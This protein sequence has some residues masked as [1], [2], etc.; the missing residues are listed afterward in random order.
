MDK[1]R[2]KEIAREW[3]ERERSQGVFAVRCAA[4]GQVW[5]SSTPNLD[6]QRNSVWFT[7]RLGTHPNRDIQAAW[8]THGEGAFAYE[9]VEA[10]EEEGFTTAG[11]KDRL[12]DR[13]RHWR[14]A[15]GA[16]AL[17]G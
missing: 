9:I 10:V 17:V 7:L 6:R 3:L 15:L 12:K 11:F 16:K 14:E 4:T 2:K 8:N 5:T 13:E 1:A